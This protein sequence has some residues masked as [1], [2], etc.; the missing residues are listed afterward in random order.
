M[1]S[2]Q[3]LFIA[4]IKKNMTKTDLR[5][6]VG[7]STATLAKMSKNEYV[8]MEVIDSICKYLDVQVEDV[9]EY[10]K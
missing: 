2:F 4:L 5:K 10:I 6:V 9:I 7:F 8:S 3:P 1:I